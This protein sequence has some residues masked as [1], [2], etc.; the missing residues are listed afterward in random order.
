M[1]PDSAERRRALSSVLSS[2][3]TRSKH[4]YQVVMP[5]ISNGRMLHFFMFTRI[6]VFQR[7]SI[8]CAR[9]KKRCTPPP[10]PPKF[11]DKKLAAMFTFQR[12][13]IDYGQEVL[14]NNLNVH[15]SSRGAHSKYVPPFATTHEPRQDR[16]PKMGT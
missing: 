13:P 5:L 1:Y 9:A 7:F 14:Q 16:V 2:Q 3:S 15:L 12:D 4:L 8:P 10:H 6:V 11:S